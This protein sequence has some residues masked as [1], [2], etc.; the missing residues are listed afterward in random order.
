MLFRS[1]PTELRLWLISKDGYVADFHEENEAYSIGANQVLPKRPQRQHGVILHSAMEFDELEAN[2]PSA[3]AGQRE[4]AIFVVH[5]HDD[6]LKENVAQ[7]L[8]RLGLDPRILH[9]QPNLGATIIEKFEINSD[10]PFAVALLTADDVGSAAGEE[11]SLRKRARQNVI[12]ELGFFLGRLG[13]KKVCALVEKDV[14]LP[15]DYDGVVYIRLDDTDHWKF[16]LMRE[17]K[18]AGM[19]ID[20]N[21]AL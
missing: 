9:E 19:S 18:A 11:S 1:R 12:L 17:L 5:G 6:V 4:D 8:R 15:S 7:F 14:E 21:N 16:D 10:V 13:R 2:S 3:A 20:A